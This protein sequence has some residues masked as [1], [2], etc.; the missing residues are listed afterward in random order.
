MAVSVITQLDSFVGYHYNWGYSPIGF[1]VK[2]F[3]Y[4]FFL[5]NRNITNGLQLRKYGIFK[6]YS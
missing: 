4:C 2:F 6:T 3:W 1:V 5:I